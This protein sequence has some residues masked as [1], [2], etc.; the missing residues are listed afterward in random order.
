MIE[1]LN[2]IIFDH[3]DN[4]LY[5][6]RMP[7]E[8]MKDLK[9]IAERSFAE[10]QKDQDVEGFEMKEIRPVVVPS[11]PEVNP[12]SVAIQTPESVVEP[13]RSEEPLQKAEDNQTSTGAELRISTL[14]S[15]PGILPYST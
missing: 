6:R 15:D 8:Q 11:V 14:V 4:N 1:S 13:V 9:T 10:R 3:P 5:N 7:Y 2:I 12:E